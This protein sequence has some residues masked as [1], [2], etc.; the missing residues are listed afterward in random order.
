MEVPFSGYFASNFAGAAYSPSQETRRSNKL[1][2]F[3]HVFPGSANLR[4]KP[5][6]LPE[7]ESEVQLQHF[8]KFLKMI[9]KYLRWFTCMV[10]GPLPR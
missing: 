9:E 2:E 6:P 3:S 5:T 10:N 8:F 4:L 1:P 7:R